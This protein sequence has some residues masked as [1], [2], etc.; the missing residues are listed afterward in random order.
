[1]AVRI[2]VTVVIPEDATVVDGAAFQVDVGQAVFD[3]PS[4]FEPYVFL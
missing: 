1:M 2:A 3:D 4:V